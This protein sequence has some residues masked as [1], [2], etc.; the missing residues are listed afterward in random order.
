MRN[1]L[2]LLVAALALA[3]VLPSSLLAAPAA[4]TACRFVLG[5]KVIH[6][7]IPATVGTCVTDEYHNPQNGDGLQETSGGLLVWR[8]R[9]APEAP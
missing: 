8:Q 2:V 4:P 3:L 5:F 9:Y 6:D 7:L 1:A